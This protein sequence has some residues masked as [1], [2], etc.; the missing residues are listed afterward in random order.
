MKHIQLLIKN[1]QKHPNQS[2]GLEFL[3]T[4]TQTM[5]YVVEIASFILQL[6]Y[7]S[8]LIDQHKYCLQ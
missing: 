2:S 5:E 3:Y 6:Q 7:F 8:L 1:K 4:Q